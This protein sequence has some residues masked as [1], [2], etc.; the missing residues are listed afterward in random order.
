MKTIFELILSV[1]LRTVALFG[2]SVLLSSVVAQEAVPSAQDLAARLSS[3]V[4]DG[5]STVLARMEI[6][7]TADGPKTVL[8]LQIKS[9]RSDAGTEVVYQVLWPKERKGESILLRD[10]RGGSPNGSL[11]MP[12]DS[13]RPITSSQ[14]NETLFGSGLAYADVI[15][16]FFGWENQSMVGTETVDRVL[17]QILESKPGKADRSIYASVRSWI[18][19]ERMVPLRIEKF[20]HAGQVSRRMTTTRVAEDDTD[21]KVAASLL[22]QQAGQDSVTEV[23][24]T[25]SRHDVS[26][27]DSE[28]TPEGLQ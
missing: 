16:N 10:M 1:L 26:F 21:K 15:E 4:K 8:Q 19:I 28:F 7:T 14:M 24:G 9:R 27:S 23:E 5:A 22:V 25:K 11:F 13:V 2:V 3:H 12:P 17:C 18:D 6:R 20:S